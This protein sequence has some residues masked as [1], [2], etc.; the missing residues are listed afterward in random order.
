MLKISKEV[1]HGGVNY[2]YKT[3]LHIISCC[4]VEAEAQ[5]VDLGLAAGSGLLGVGDLRALVHPAQ[6]GVTFFSP[7]SVN[8]EIDVWAVYLEFPG[9]AETRPNNERR[10]YSIWG[11]LPEAGL[12]PS[13]LVLQGMAPEVGGSESGLW[14]VGWGTEEGLPYCPEPL[15]PQ[16]PP[17]PMWTFFFAFNCFLG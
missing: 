3:E 4:N 9:T 10:S 2:N 14:G 11:W 1:K 15:Q 13:P 16:R 12:H 8:Q 5:L 7:K 17:F 6:K